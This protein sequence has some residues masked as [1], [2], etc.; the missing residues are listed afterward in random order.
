[1]ENFIQLED[2]EMAISG[3]VNSLNTQFINEQREKYGHEFIS[4][5]HFR[6]FDEMCDYIQ[7]KVLQDE[8][9]LSE[10][11]KKRIIGFF[12]TFINNHV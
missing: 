6:R 7:E 3:K 10:D 1:M 2:L 11:A 5:W 4:F 8:N 9:F 12:M